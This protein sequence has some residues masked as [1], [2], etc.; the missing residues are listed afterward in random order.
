VV[1]LAAQAVPTDQPSLCTAGRV[2]QVSA[3]PGTSESQA[4]AGRPLTIASLNIAGE[5]Q[6][7]EPLTAWA[8]HRT[9][10]V[11]FLQEVGGEDEDGASFAAALSQRLG[12]GSAY[13]PAR[14]YGETGNAQGLAI[15]SRYP[16]ADAGVRL[17]P[18][19]QLRFRSRCRI[20]VAATVLTPAGPVRVVNVHLDTRINKARRLAQVDAA[21]AAVNGF[22]GPRVVGGDFNTNDF[23]WIDA[24]WP[25]PFAQ[26]QAKAVQEHMSA[27]GFVTPFAETRGT[28]PILWIA[29]KLDW[30]FLSP[31]LETGDAGVDDV[32][33]TDHRG[34]W[35]RASASPS[36]RRSGPTAVRR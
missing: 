17:L 19:N 1:V 4:S 14:P 33:L 23:T 25:I 9:A 27:G 34:I 26:K 36:A 18:Y 20:A 15:V 5:S 32:P 12:Y 13:A 21:I 7:A 22:D 30:L 11:L 8:N 2:Y 16:L 24:T 3:T 10:D 31:D 6:I 29:L 35:T 28:Y